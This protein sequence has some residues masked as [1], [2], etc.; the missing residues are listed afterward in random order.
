MFYI[1]R[2]GQTEWN[3]EWRY[4]GQKDSPLTPKGIEQAEEAREQLRKIHF[5]AVFS[6][7]LYRAKHTAEIITLEKKLAFQ[8][9]VLLR[10][11][12]SGIFEGKIA[13]E[14]DE[15]L[16]TALDQ[17]EKLS[18]E[19]KWHSRPIDSWESDEE[20]VGRFITFLRETAVGY[21]GK[22]VLVVTHGG[23]IRTFLMHI[24]FMEKGKLPSGSILNGAY[25]KVRCDG[26]DFFV[27]EVKGLKA[28][29]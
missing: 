22:T 7:D 13:S 17:F 2:H 12:S 15:K 24:G 5:D 29:T 1:V 6:S 23:P 21:A 19:E 27:D 18:P 8:T 4:Q 10:E 20:I 11:R 25:I 26:V 16:K 14:L 9:S 28:D 3:V